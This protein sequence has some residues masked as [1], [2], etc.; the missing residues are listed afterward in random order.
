MM[1]VRG[2][3]QQILQ[4][5]ENVEKAGLLNGVPYGEGESSS[6]LFDRVFC[7]QQTNLAVF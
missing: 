2:Q 3:N 1:Q 6:F 4:V 7:D 5:F